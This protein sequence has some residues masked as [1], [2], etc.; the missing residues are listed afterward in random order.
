M[1]RNGIPADQ[2]AI[3]SSSVD[4][5]DGINLLSR[6]CPIRFIISANALKEGWDC[7]FA[8]SLAILGPLKKAAALTQLLG[9]I[10]R[11]PYIKRTGVEPLDRCYVFT[12][13]A[14]VLEVVNQIAAELRDNMGLGDMAGQIAVVKP[15]D[16]KLQYRAGVRERFKC[17]EG[18]I[19]LPR[20]AVQHNGKWRPFYRESDLLPLVDWKAIDI[21]DAVCRQDYMGRGDTNAF[22]INL[23][24]QYNRLDDQLP[25]EQRIIPTLLARDL[26]AHIPNSWQAMDIAQT[27]I[28]AAKA[29]FG[30]EKLARHFDLFRKQALEE[31]ERQVDAQTE[32][33]FRGLVQL[34]DLQMVLRILDGKDYLVPSYINVNSQNTNPNIAKSLFDP[35]VLDDLNSL[36]KTVALTLEN[37]AD[38]LMWWRNEVGSSWFNIEGWKPNKKVYPDFIAASTG[39]EE[40]PRVL[41]VESKGDHLRDN[42]DTKYKTALFEI[43][44]DARPVGWAELN[45]L[46]GGQVM[47]F[48]IVYANDFD[49]RIC[50]MLA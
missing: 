38:I 17:F 47:K 46:R 10:L 8:Y 41:I 23:Q 36:E 1:I 33:I 45:E 15:G 35:I 31:T 24:G 42:P 43:F 4:E 11:Q 7:P 9:R 40:F 32:A 22:I 12:H 48:Q 29:T 50:N 34:G 26:C 13:H 44:N 2:I 39:E 5:L 28:A 19:V 14:N 18:K 6:E 3:K 30:E 49:Q 25:E 37:H 20:L 21:R 16:S 27:A